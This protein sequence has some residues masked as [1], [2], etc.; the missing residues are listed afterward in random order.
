[1]HITVLPLG[2][3]ERSPMFASFQALL[4]KLVYFKSRTGT[5]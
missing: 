5:G 1:M 3:K 2:K 4:G